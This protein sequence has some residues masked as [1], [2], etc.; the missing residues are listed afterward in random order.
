MYKIPVNI[1]IAFGYLFINSK[2][3]QLKYSPN[4]ENNHEYKFEVNLFS[5]SAKDKEMIPAK[6]NNAMP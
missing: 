3:F 5:A 1:N 6:I 2:L 4:L